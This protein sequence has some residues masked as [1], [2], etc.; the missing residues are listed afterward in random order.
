MCTAIKAKY[1][2]YENKEVC[3]QTTLDATLC[4]I[5]KLTATVELQTDYGPVVIRNV[6]IEVTDSE[7]DQILLGSD[8]LE[9]LDIDVN[10]LLDE[11]AGKEFNMDFD[12]N[13]PLEFGS[14]D[15]SLIRAGLSD[16]VNDALSKGLPE[17]EHDK[18]HSLLQSHADVCRLKLED[19]PPAKV[20]PMKVSYN[21][22]APPIRLANRK[23]C[24]QHR[25]FMDYYT[26]MLEKYG[27]IYRNP[28]AKYVSPSYVVNKVSNPTDITK[29]YRFTVD[30]REPNSLVEQPQW[31]MPVLE[32][33]Q[34][35]ITGAKYFIALDMTAGYWQCPLH[36]DSQE[37]YSFATHSGVFTSRRVMQGAT[38]S[39][40]Y[41]QAMMQKAFK[42]RLYKSIIVWLDDLLLYSFTIDGLYET[43]L[44]VLKVCKSLGL[45]LSISKCT[46]FSTKIR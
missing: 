35:N 21:N 29:H 32:Q 18:W 34:E 7:L 43:L 36:K 12:P 31:P 1:I 15:E 27:I 44:F 14:N 2:E 33:V 25:K 3:N 30:S 6:P 38:G 17:C 28:N 24:L 11:L 22:S 41:F 5:G 40:Q 20:E 37:L 16:L 26:D 10:A 42:E 19:D 39:V 8:L 46:L 9:Y 23:Y 45:K 4:L 13:S